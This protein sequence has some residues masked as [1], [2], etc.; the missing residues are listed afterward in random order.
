MS[1]NSLSSQIR[2]CSEEMERQRHGALYLLAEQKQQA[3]KRA[4]QVPLPLAIGLAFAGG[5]VA[6][7][8][9]ATPAPATLLRWYMAARAF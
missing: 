2:H 1:L 4:R 5:F 8:F 3:L 6:E 9:F 7:R